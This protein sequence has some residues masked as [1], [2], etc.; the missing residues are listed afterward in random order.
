MTEGNNL[1]NYIREAVRPIFYET[2]HTQQCE[3]DTTNRFTLSFV[4][5][6][7]GMGKEGTPTKS[8]DAES[9]IHRNPVLHRRSARHM[10]HQ[11]IRPNMARGE[12]RANRAKPKG[13]RVRNRAHPGSSK[14]RDAAKCTSASIKRTNHVSLRRLIFTFLSRLSS[15]SFCALLHP[16]FCFFSPFLP[17]TPSLSFA[18]CQFKAAIQ[19]NAPR[20]SLDR[21]NA[22]SYEKHF[23]K[24]E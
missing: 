2:R 13:V 6:L 11:Q 14:E 12:Q 19:L 8:S 7:N 18:G 3:R 16:C 24:Q 17:Y 22:C 23:A 5:R 1:D 4:A 9:C 20:P 10:K 15:L 21:R